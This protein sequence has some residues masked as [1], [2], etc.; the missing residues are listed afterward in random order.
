MI[1]NGL[2]EKL[3]KALQFPSQRKPME[4]ILVHGKH[5][6]T[7]KYLILILKVQV[8]QAGQPITNLIMTDAT[9]DQ[10]RANGKNK[11]MRTRI[12]EFIAGILTVQ[13]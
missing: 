2:Q 5:H 9:T 3:R 7:I 4:N 8:R 1:I 6:Q 12:P 11:L 10:G 13:M